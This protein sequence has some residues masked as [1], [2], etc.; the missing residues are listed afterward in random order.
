M[1]SRAA[2]LAAVALIGVGALAACGDDDE[3]SAEG[4]TSESAAADSGPEEVTLVADETEDGYS[5]DL[6]ATPTAETQSVVFDNQGEQEHFLVFAKINE[7]Y[8]LDEAVKLQGKKGSAEV[9]VEQGAGPGETRKLAVKGPIEPGNYAMLCPIPSPEG[10]H[11]KLGQL[12]EF[13]I[14]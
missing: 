5:F 1:R 12:E 13:T 11:Y 8:T 2:L 10:P 14:E 9:L 4:T 6:S 3:S 7:G